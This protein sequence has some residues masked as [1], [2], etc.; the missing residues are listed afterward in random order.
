MEQVTETVAVE[1]APSAAAAVTP[2]PQ[3]TPMAFS[4]GTPGWA[5]R[6]LANPPAAWTEWRNSLKPQGEAVTVALASEG[7]T[8]YVIV[9]PEKATAQEKRSASELQLWLGKITG[10]EF[11]IVPDSEA[12][13]EREL[14]V[15]NTSRVTEEQAAQ[16]AGLREGYVI[17]VEGERVFFLGGER[18]GPLYGVLALLE[19]DLGVRWISPDGSFAPERP[20]LRA[21]I[22][23]RRV[24]PPFLVRDM[25]SLAGSEWY[26]RNR[27]NGPFD[28]VA[29]GFPPGYSY[30][31]SH[32]VHTLHYLVPPDKYF[33]SNP[34][35]YSLINGK[36]QWDKA[37]LC[38]G[39]PEVARVAAETLR[40]SLTREG[41][42]PGRWQTLPVMIGPM[43]WGG[44][45][46]CPLCM[47][48]EE[49]TGTRG[50][51][52][53]DFVNRVA[54]L[55]HEDLP[56]VQLQV[57]PYWNVKQPPTNKETTAHPGVGVRFCTDWGADFTWPYHSFYDPEYNREDVRGGAQRDLFLRWKEISRTPMHV[58]AYPHQYRNTPAPEPNTHAVAENLRFFAEQDVEKVHMHQ[59]N[60]HPHWD[61]GW[62]TPWVLSKL[63]WNPGL[64]VDDVMQ[65][66]IWSGYYGAAA[67]AVAEYHRFLVE[68]AIHHNDFT[69]QRDWIYAI[70]DEG[71]F[72]D[73][74]VEK[75][76]AILDRGLEMAGADEQVRRRLEELKLGVVY[77][78][79]A[80]LFMQMRNDKEPP[81]A[82][83]YETVRLELADLL[84]RLGVEKLGFYEG[85]RTIPAF[86]EAMEE[87]RRLRFDNAWL[88]VEA[89]GEWRYRPDAEDAGVEE[90]WFA[91]ESADGEE[92]SPV[93]VP[94]FLPAKDS[95]PPLG[96]GWYFVTFTLDEAQR[97]T[98]I[99]LHFGGVDEQAWV[100]VNG[101]FIGEHTLESEFMVGEEITVDDLWNRSFKFEVP[102]DRLKTGVNVLMVRFHNSAE[103]AGIHQPVRINLPDPPK[104]EHTKGEILHEDFSGAEAGDVP[105]AWRRY[106]QESDGRANG[107]AEVR[108]HGA[109]PTLHLQ[110]RRSNVTVWSASDQVLPE[111]S[112]WVLQF[113]FRLLGTDPTGRLV[114]QAS[115]EGGLLGLKRGTRGAGSDYLPLLQLCNQGK[116]GEAVTLYGL[117][118]VL[119][120]N[121][122]PN[123]WHRVAIRR[124]GT[125]WEF[126][127]DGQPV[128][129]VSGKDTDLRGLAFGSFRDW[130]NVMQ[131][132]EIADL[133]IG[134]PQN[135]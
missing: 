79:A 113:D 46:E 5:R 43:D 33:E 55:L 86:A 26:A 8:D 11:P 22:V 88:P 1:A 135:P 93:Q 54:S 48:I 2:A 81:D 85:S 50:G 16:A 53:L 27:F 44:E 49:K 97:Q 45:C 39:N 15:G 7:R 12:P 103:N 108:R 96:Y 13:R 72:R 74:F 21:E 73:G 89:W 29:P 47:E 84:N 64:N 129:T 119:T 38:L 66:F 41:W 40:K 134:R 127:L 120:E 4:S 71:M 130:Q 104:T 51:L 56:E 52:Y 98:G 92:W 106:V 114:Y 34:E 65:D 68:S 82:A 3:A 19:E 128:K 17:A 110:D 76:R 42:T 58:Y 6:Y 62:F 80:K 107:I 83:R 122:A 30:I 132:V 36:R 118:E 37:Q 100:Y 75:A 57:V 35:F 125:D 116:P 117:G 109:R 90:K 67:P 115:P 23:P 105:D 70:H 131:D 61:G 91:A 99:E 32:G 63:M 121:L 133:K 25:R 95:G 59:W 123:E 69:L 14:S 20:T 10:A 9:V 102:A 126:F 87:E 60:R 18:P 112:D 111:D 28:V 94:G 24:E 78:D 101:E 124:Q 31:W 77:V